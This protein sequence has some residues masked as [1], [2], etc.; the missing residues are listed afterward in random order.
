MFKMNQ[1]KKISLIGAQST[2][3]TTLAKYLANY[4]E[5]EW[6]LEYARDYFTK[7]PKEFE[8]SDVELIIKKQI[9]LENEA[10]RKS[11][12]YLFCDTDIL[13]TIVWSDIF[14]NTVSEKSVEF[15]KNNPHDLYLLLENDL[16][17]VKEP[18]REDENLRTIFYNKFI[19]YLKQL[20]LNYYTVSGT[21]FIRAQ[22][23]IR[24]ISNHF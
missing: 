24:I 22:N 16:K 7:H 18:E 17:F 6:V 8:Y 4:Y 13:T 2:G 20:E 19:I 21:D 12:K 5:T 15:I 23:A 1:I 10:L 14:F 11:N 3:K 9:Q